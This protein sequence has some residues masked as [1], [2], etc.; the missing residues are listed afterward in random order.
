MAGDAEKKKNKAKNQKAASS[1]SGPVAPTGE[2]LEARCTHCGVSVKGTP[3]PN[4]R[5]KLLTCPV[6]SN[7]MPVWTEKTNWRKKI[8]ERKPPLLAKE[9]AT[10]GER[11]VLLDFLEQWCRKIPHISDTR[12]PSKITI[13]D[14]FT[15]PTFWV[16]VNVYWEQRHFRRVSRQLR[17]AETPQESNPIER[18][19]A[20]AVACTGYPFRG[21]FKTQSEAL[22]E[23]IDVPDTGEYEQCKQCDVNGQ[24]QCKTCVGR[25]RLTCSKCDGTTKHNCPNCKGSGQVTVRNVAQELGTCRSCGGSGMKGALA[26]SLAQE[27]G[28]SAV[29]ERCYGRG[30]CTQSVDR[31]YKEPCGNCKANG[32]VRCDVCGQDGK[33]PCGPC[34]A[35]GKVACEGCGAR[36][37]V[38]SWWVV[39][40]E[41]TKVGKGDGPFWDQQDAELLQA[42][43][44]I[45]KAWDSPDNESLTV[46]Q[47]DAAE[48][49]EVQTKGLEFLPEPLHKGFRSVCT[50]ASSPT[51]PSKRR[52]WHEAHVESMY[53]TGMT[54]TFFSSEQFK[55]W[56][57]GN[58]SSIETFPTPLTSQAEQRLKQAILKWGREGSKVQESN[59]KTVIRDVR[60]SNDIAKQDIWLQNA[61]KAAG[62]P[63]DLQQLANKEA[64]A[65]F[66]RAGVN[67]TVDTVKNAASAVGGWLGSLL[68]G[69][70]KS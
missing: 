30:V 48:L 10:D 46:W 50:A 63:E 4:A 61:V 40:R 35:T 65:V 22:K 3:R 6:C 14:S 47:H 18:P 68:G 20:W 37:H 23:T 5:G 56:L 32:Q 17:G 12:F 62:V 7:Q 41:V 53:C 33:V 27:T 25:G 36:R 39:D 2:T 11:G 49:K 70:K 42:E 45:R 57:C 55:A 21:H 64:W 58:I 8:P 15:A 26:A 54:Y 59:K 19:D 1:G 67:K 60:V 13:V 69:K 28:R 24:I 38:Y 66:T 31:S 29:C 51:Q 9:Q 16:R 52:V 34:N 43:E 44:G